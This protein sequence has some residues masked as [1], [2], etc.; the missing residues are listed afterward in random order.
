MI[1]FRVIP[2]STGRGLDDAAGVLKKNA[3]N[4][5]AII[6]FPKKNV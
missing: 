1:W 4:Y 3:F 6:C 2:Y 5:F